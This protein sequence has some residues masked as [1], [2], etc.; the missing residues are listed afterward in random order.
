MSAAGSALA[1]AALALLPGCVSFGPKPP[2]S[3]IRFAPAAMAP[4]DAGAPLT[5]ARAVTVMVPT[6]PNELAAPRVPVRSGAADLAYLKDAQYAD[7]PARLF[8]DLLMETIRARTGR[9]AL[10]GRDY[11]LAGGSVLN[12]RIDTLSVD[13]GQRRV[14]L[15]VDA[16]LK[17]PNQDAMTR[18]FEAHV[19]VTAVTA[20][21]V[22][23]ALS[24]AANDVAVQIADW[25]GR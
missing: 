15:V 13:A 5:P 3:L 23:P 11:H 14:D 25:V 8:R 16:V 7:S 2:P 1:L 17:T 20:P 22:T 12:S 9:P 6:T 10:E 4:A 18:R 21:A 19:P 24:Q